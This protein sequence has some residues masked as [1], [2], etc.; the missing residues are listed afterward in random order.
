MN[1]EPGSAPLAGFVHSDNEI[2]ASEARPPSS[3]GDPPTRQMRNAQ[4]IR[5]GTR[6]PEAASEE[7]ALDI[8]PGASS[9][10]SSTDRV[11]AKLSK[12]QLRK[13]ERKAR[14]D[15]ERELM[16]KIEAGKYRVPAHFIPDVPDDGLAS[17]LM[18]DASHAKSDAIMVGQAINGRWQ[19]DAEKRQALYNRVLERGLGTTD[20]R[21]LFRA[22]ETVLK[23]E[24]QNQDDELRGDAT[25]NA[26]VQGN[27]HIYIPDNGRGDVVGP[28]Q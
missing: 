3:A 9:A 25:T 27:V 28:S 11:R 23:A 26:G 12:K 21:T 10:R 1:K 15:A 8:E 4:R 6:E 24:K 20:N 16:A 18:V 22:F 7:H 13:I 19:S 5:V 2:V 14:R 17:R